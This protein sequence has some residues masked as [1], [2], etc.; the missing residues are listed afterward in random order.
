MEAELR[1]FEMDIKKYIFSFLN[2]LRQKWNLP[3]LVYVNLFEENLKNYSS[4][5]ENSGNLSHLGIVGNPLKNEFEVIQD[6]FLINNNMKTEMMNH[7]YKSYTS[8]MKD[9]FNSIA[10]VLTPI[11]WGAVL[12]QLVTM[13][14]FKSDLNLIKIEM[15]DNLLSFAYEELHPS[16]SINWIDLI[17]MH[18]KH[19]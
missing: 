11:H 15:N 5:L 8:L 12:N 7:Y 17:F 4:T 1:N 16:I 9:S 13:A 10:M 14:L 19:E 6:E 3:K 2:N 18:Q